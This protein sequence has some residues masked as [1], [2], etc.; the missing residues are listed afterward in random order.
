MSQ[1]QSS[2]KGKVILGYLLIFAIAV[3]SVWFIYNEILKIAIPDKD[4]NSENKK[5]IQIS[6]AIANLY[7]SEA[8]GRNSIL[9]GSSKDFKEYQK[10]LDSVNNQIEQI[11]TD[12]D[13]AQLGKLDTIQNLLKKKKN[14]INGI[15]QFRNF[16]NQ[17]NTFDRAVGKIYKVK[18]SLNRSVK[19]IQFR[20]NSQMREFLNNVLTKKQMDS[21]SKLPV[22]NEKLTSEIEKM[23]TQVVIKDNKMKYQLFRKEQS[24]QDENR[25]ISDQLRIVLSSLEKEILQKSYLKINKSKSAINNTIETIAWIG[26][27]TFCLLILFAGIIIRDLTI[28]QNYRKQ[29]EE[30]NDD[31]ENLLRSKT[32]LMATVTHDIQTPLGSVIGFSD[33]LK[34]TETTPKQKQYLD[35]IKHSAQ[36]IIKLVNDLLDFSKLENNK[37]NIEK[38]SFNFKELIESTCKPLEPN[39]TNKNIELRFDVDDALDQNFISDPYR[40]KQILTNL[41]SNA[42]KF[43][44]RGSVEVSAKLENHKIIVAVIDTGIGIAKDEQEAVFKEFTQA[45]AGIEK[46]FGGTGL[47]LTIAKRLLEMLDGTIE[48]ES[49]EGQGSIFTIEIPAIASEIKK[50]ESNKLQPSGAFDF[51]ENR[52]I[53]IVDDDAMQLSLMKE[54]FS[55]YPVQITT[56]TDASNV[57][58]M[59]EN[60]KFDLILSD[61]QMPQIDG[62][63]LVRIIRN[64]NNPEIATI[65][66]VALSGKRDLN[67]EDFTSKGFTAFHPKPLQLDELLLLIKAIFKNEKFTNTKIR[68]S[69]NTGKLFDL[70]TLNQFTQNDPH[71]LKMIV[72]N[73]IE[74]TQENCSVLKWAAAENDLEKLSETAHKMI[75]MFRQMEVHSVVVL[76][77][78]LEDQKLNLEVNGMKDYVAN[79]CQKIEELVIRLKIEVL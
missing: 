30:L 52:K 33:L 37:I 35:N 16:Y 45:H 60:E 40:L 71:A 66:V 48:L 13:P 64:N 72:E 65:P 1:K 39:A 28:S 8:A 67:P 9:T 47:G 50:Y 42:I 2:T 44:Q 31:K 27:I 20:D 62:F 11:K 77:E 3:V 26:A 73:F 6:N 54:I 53:L 4:V 74:S 19:P 68:K 5:I 10:L 7:A 12:S 25:I 24:L 69:E 75:P 51:L 78:P 22:S 34:N 29:L 59:L 21:L 17:Q 18:D 32:M 55:N 76:L 63:E 70:K 49:I 41:I 43:T 61:I 56:I 79:S 23:L 58:A 38:V 36:Y 57:K 14:S 15:I 46:K